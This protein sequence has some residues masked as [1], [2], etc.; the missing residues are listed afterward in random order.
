[1]LLSFILWILMVACGAISVIFIQE[2]VQ[3]KLDLVSYL[4]DEHDLKEKL[5]NIISL[6][7]FLFFVVSPFFVEY[8][9]DNNA[10]VAVVTE[11][12]DVEYKTFG[13]IEPFAK[14]KVIR[15]PSLDTEIGMN[16][17]V[18][19]INSV[20]KLEIRH[21]HI[22]YKIT[23]IKKYVARGF[24]EEGFGKKNK[25][26][27]VLS[28]IIIKVQIREIKDLFLNDQIKLIKSDQKL[29]EESRR[30]NGMVKEFLQ[31]TLDR[32][33]SGIEIIK[34]R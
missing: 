29:L 1:M 10:V 31:N 19:G 4:E 16:L 5:V 9:G 20:P 18:Q 30:Y 3:K 8:P 32:L 24:G 15:L 7:P 23:D 11:T 12:N 33:D 28:D 26:H 13:V 34:V 21:T 27:R 14:G 6:I 22:Y 17:G 2:S 25:L